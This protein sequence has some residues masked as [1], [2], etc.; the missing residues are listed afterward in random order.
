MASSGYSGTPLVKKLGIREGSTVYV[1]NAPKEY[2]EWIFPVPE[3]IQIKKSI[4]GELDFV[5]LF[6]KDQKTFKKVFVDAQNHLKKDGMMWVSWPKKSSKVE[7][8][9]DE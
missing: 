4:G 3:M 2:F 9:L 1:H 6:V 5:H 7:T 8:D